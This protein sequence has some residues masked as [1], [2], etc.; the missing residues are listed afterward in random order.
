MRKLRSSA[1]LHTDFFIVG[2]FN[3]VRFAA[4]LCDFNAGSIPQVQ[5]DLPAFTGWHDG[6]ADGYVNASAPRE[7]V[8]AAYHVPC[9]T[10][11]DRRDRYTGADG[12]D[13]CTH[14]KGLQTG[15]GGKGSFREKDDGLTGL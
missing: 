8:V 15:E 6:R 14:A 4:V 1:H 11:G 3:Q 10:D 12:R 13:K 9:T 7:P 2:T 5:R